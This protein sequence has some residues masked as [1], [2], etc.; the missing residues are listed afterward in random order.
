MYVLLART[1]LSQLTWRPTDLK[2]IKYMNVHPYLPPADISFEGQW[3]SLRASI[4]LNSALVGLKQGTPKSL[5]L[6]VQQATKVLDI[7]SDPDE[8]GT[9]VPMT[10]CLT[11]EERAKALF[12]RGMARAALKDLDEAQKDLHQA[13]KL[14][15]EDKAVEAELKKVQAKRDELKKKQQKAF[16]KMFG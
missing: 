5:H 1:R 12:R 14:V 3:M 7:H 13:Q 4:L 10:K 6:C 16:G 2:A 8:A 15:P 11:K 9:I